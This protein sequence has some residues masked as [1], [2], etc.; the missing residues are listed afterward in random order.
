M[1]QVAVQ[2]YPPGLRQSPHSH[3]TWSVT[4]VLAG[5]IRERVGCR[6]VLG[7]PFDLVIKPS[8]VVHANDFGETGSRTLQLVMSPVVAQQ[9]ADANPA[10][11]QWKW[12]HSG[13][14]LP[15]MLELL[16]AIRLAAALFD[17]TGTFKL[18]ASLSTYL[19]EARFAAPL[20][21]DSITIRQLLTHTHG[22]GDGPVPIRLAYTG[23]YNG[24]THL[25]SLLSAHQALS[26]RQYR[27][28]NTGYN[29]A[30]LAM[31][32]VTSESWKQ[33]LDRLIFTPLGMRNTSGFVSKFSTEQLAMPYR[34]E[35]SGQ[36]RLR[37]GKFDSNMQ[38]AGGLVTTL[39]DETKW[40]EANINNGS[41]DGKQLIPAAAMR[42]AHRV[43][44][45]FNENI[46]GLQT[47]GYALGWNV[48]LRNN[49]DTILFH[50]GG[51]PGFATSISFMPQRRI[52]IVVMANNGD[53]GIALTDLASQVVYSILLDGTTISADSL[54]RLRNRVDQQRA[55]I[56]A[57]RERR[58]ARP[59]TLPLPFT[60]YAGRY[61][62]DVMGT[63]VLSVNG[64]GKLELQAGVARSDVE[65][66]NGE[67]NQLRHELFGG[68]SVMQMDVQGGR[69]VAAIMN[70]LRFTRVQ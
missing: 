7:R 45:P 64:E 50:G 3:D 4:L 13:T 20:N 16:A 14:A 18:D 59:Q 27:Y 30:T 49:R 24:N 8:G 6:E 23:E 63:L 21:A 53:L 19:P 58:A 29:V 33:T 51:F 11:N 35:P 44:A 39:E 40:L 26:D 46:R 5:S 32:K 57:D 28:S 70:G 37:Y 68:G 55:G 34:T 31:D 25:I 38:S 65:V 56:R 60:A 41:I 47:V 43:H 69:V 9:V 12:V 54:Q 22:I 66:F 48:G 52:G 10:L 62:N 67:R 61:T 2:Q 36:V 1:L 17:A 42:E 15:S